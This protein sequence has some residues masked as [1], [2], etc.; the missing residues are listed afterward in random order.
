MLCPSSAFPDT[1]NRDHET[2]YSN[3]DAS[4]INIDPLRIHQLIPKERNTT[5]FNE[6]LLSLIIEEIK[7]HNLRT[8]NPM[9]DEELSEIEGVL[10]GENNFLKPRSLVDLADYLVTFGKFEFAYVTY[11]EAVGLGLQLYEMDSNIAWDI[12]DGLLGFAKIIRKGKLVEC[13]NY[14]DVSQQIFRYL[15]SIFGS[16]EAI[17]FL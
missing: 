1:Q 12:H 8:F 11:L 3:V 6:T 4:E 15:G 16:E 7:K 2:N 5:P 17:S 9:E 14:A 10:N 13:V